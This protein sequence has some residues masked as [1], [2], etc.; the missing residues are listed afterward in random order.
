L[1]ICINY[2]NEGPGSRS[3][4]NGHN[5]RDNEMYTSRRVIKRTYINGDRLQIAHDPNI[6]NCSLYYSLILQ[7]FPH[8]RAGV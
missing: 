8:F 2:L 3:G 1:R 7:Q 5:V 6:W 4:D